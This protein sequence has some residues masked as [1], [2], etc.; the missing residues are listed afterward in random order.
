MIFV[1]FARAAIHSVGQS[2]YVVEGFEAFLKA[3]NLVLNVIV[4]VE[5][6][7]WVPHDL[8]CCWI[9]LLFYHV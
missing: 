1:G 9:I 3:D 8:V 4:L 6:Y 2:L 5:F 7:R